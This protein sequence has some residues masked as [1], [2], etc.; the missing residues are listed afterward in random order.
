MKRIAY[1]TLLICAAFLAATNLTAG[2]HAQSASRKPNVII[3]LSDDQG[4][5]DL[6]AHGNPV[7]RTPNLDRLRGESIRL[8]DFH[9]APMCTPTRGQLLTGVDA[10]RNGATSVTAG[11]SLLRPGIP[12]MAEIFKASGYRTGIFG[13]WHLGD[14]WP[15][16]PQHRGFDESVYHIGWGVSSLAATWLNDNFDDFFFHNGKLEKYPGYCTDVWFDQSMKWIKERQLRNEP[17]FVYLPTNAPHGPQWVADKY[18]QPYEG[19]GPA[20]FFGMIANLDENMGRLDEFLRASGLYDNTIVIF[21]NDNG[22][23]AGV[24]TFNAGMRDRKTSYYEGGHRAICFLRWPEGDLR[25]AGDVDVLTEVQDLLPTL[26]DLLS[27]RAPKGAKFDGVTL[28]GLL[29]GKTDRLRSLRDRIL[30]V[31]YGQTPARYD[32]AVMWN[33]WRL[34]KGTELYDLKTDPGQERNVAAEHADVAKKLRTHY[35]GW[36]AEVGPRVAEFVPIV[37]GASQENPVRLTAVDWADVYCDNT[38]NCLLPGANKNGPWT[39]EIAQSGRYEFAL[40]RWP[41]EA[42][43]ALTAGMPAV[44]LTDGQYPEGKAMPIAKAR[45]KIG[46]HDQ[47]LSVK[48]NDK[49]VTFILPL[50]ATAKTEMQTWF[51][52]AQG[53]ELSGAYFVYARRF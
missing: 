8:T 11:R 24:N 31:Q 20:R 18:K 23:T 41:V 6:S 51:Y 36:W 10:L 38:V 25:A 27:L 46:D 26:I 19:K 42:D 3:I 44:K 39:V 7:L 9:V 50:K 33:K 12:T 43:A 21:M 4:Y 17:F 40:R 52:D 16:L 15:N 5:G 1:Q 32:A 34:V 37:I 47:T 48:A 29:R 53:K 30:V 13:K 14:S 2:V 22:G 28:A 49:A 45:L 35:D